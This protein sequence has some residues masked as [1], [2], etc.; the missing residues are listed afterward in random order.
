M[1]ASE[2]AATTRQSDGS[3]VAITHHLY[4]TLM[5]RQ[6]DATIAMKNTN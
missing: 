5:Q 2:I 6:A 4:Q 1:F 3:H